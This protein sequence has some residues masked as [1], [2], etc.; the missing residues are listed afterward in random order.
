MPVFPCHLY[1]VPG[2]HMGHGGVMYKYVGCPDAEE[3]KRLTAIGWYASLSEATAGKTAK[4]VIQTAEAM[5]DAVDAIVPET[6]AELE[7]MAKE[8]GIG[9]NARTKDE[10]LIQRIAEALE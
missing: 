6:R 4:E 1:K 2:P 10:T 8:L 9:F 7:G 3:F 5:E